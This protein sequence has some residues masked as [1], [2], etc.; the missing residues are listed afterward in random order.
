MALSIVSRTC[1][2]CKLCD[3]QVSV[4]YVQCDF[5]KAFHVCNNHVHTLNV[6]KLQF[7]LGKRLN[8]LELHDLTALYDFFSDSPVTIDYVATSDV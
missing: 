1:Q 4:V 6:L 8:F 7:I 3:I 5:L 2:N